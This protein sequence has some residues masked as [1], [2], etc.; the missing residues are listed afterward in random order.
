MPSFLRELLLVFHDG[1]SLSNKSD[2]FNLLPGKE[3][4]FL[5]K[6]ISYPPYDLNLNIITILLVGFVIIDFFSL[7]FNN[8]ISEIDSSP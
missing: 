1:F 2:C 7:E 8:Y 4:F 3:N 5:E 6:K